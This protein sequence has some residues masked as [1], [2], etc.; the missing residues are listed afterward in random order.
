[1]IAGATQGDSVK[2]TT[3]VGWLDV[4]GHWMTG[5]WCTKP[6]KNTNVEYSRISI[7][8]IA[9]TPEPPKAVG[10]VSKFLAE[11]LRAA[12]QQL[13]LRPRLEMEAISKQQMTD[14][15]VRFPFGF[16][17]GAI[18]LDLVG[19]CSKYLA[20]K[21]HLVLSRSGFNLC[22]SPQLSRQR[23]LA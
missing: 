4:V 19:L 2:E 6:S 21:K 9:L 16:Q 1:M 5:K 18:C 17:R 7:A 10:A 11:Q 15:S 23:Q 8:A 22:P 14:V 3:A 20:S 12:E 13:A